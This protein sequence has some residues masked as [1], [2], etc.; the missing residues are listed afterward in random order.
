MLLHT[1]PP[2]GFLWSRNQFLQKA[3]SQHPGSERKTL[4]KSVLCTLVTHTTDTESSHR[5][6]NLC[7]MHKRRANYQIKGWQSQKVMGS[8]SQRHSDKYTLNTSLKGLNE[9][10]TQRR[11]VILYDVCYLYQERLVWP[12]TLHLS[13]LPLI[14]FLSFMFLNQYFQPSSPAF[15]SRHQKPLYESWLPK[16]CWPTSPF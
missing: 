6:R 8:G 16:A 9:E 1:T 7:K 10:W 3:D 5:G 4:I 13:L 15:L 14:S 11:T 2:V 12:R